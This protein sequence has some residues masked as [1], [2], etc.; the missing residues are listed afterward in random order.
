DAIVAYLRSIPP[1]GGVGAG[2]PRDRG[3][4][5]PLPFSPG[6]WPRCAPCL[7]LSVLSPPRPPARRPPPP[8]AAAAPAPPPA[9][10]AGRRAGGA[11]APQ[12]ARPAGAA[13]QGGGPRASQP[14]VDGPWD[15]QTEREKIH[16][17]V[18]TKGLDHPWGM[19]FLP[20]GDM[21]VTERPGR[22]R[23]VHKDGKLDPTPIAGLP[24]IRAAVIGGLLGVALPPKFA[25]NRLGCISPPKPRAAAARA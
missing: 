16:V 10:P 17:T 23:V 19:A 4:P 3:A 9:R 22:L 6:A 12:G 1:I 8:R 15:F 21:L 13:G 20:N 25:P 14:L 11:L 2:G 24:K 18:M 5:V 7:F